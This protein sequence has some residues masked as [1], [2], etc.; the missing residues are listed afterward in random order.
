MTGFLSRG[1]GNAR[2]DKQRKNE[3]VYRDVIKESDFVI[4]STDNKDNLKEDREYWLSVDKEFVRPLLQSSDAHN[5]ESVGE[6]FTWIKSDLTFEG[7]RQIKFEPESRVSVELD[8]PD[9]KES[10]LILDKIEIEGNSIELNKNLN[11]IIGGRSTG[12][13][14]LLNTIAKKVGYDTTVNEEEVNTFFDLKDFKDEDFKVVWADDKTSDNRKVTF[15][16]QEYMIEVA[17]NKGKFD[18]LIKTIVNSKGYNKY[19]DKYHQ[20]V[21][22]IQ[23]KI[24]NSILNIE[25]A[26]KK[27]TE[28][29]VKP[30]GDEVGIKYAIEA[31]E[32]KIKLFQ[33]NNPYFKKKIKEFR[34]QKAKLDDLKSKIENLEKMISVLNELWSQDP[35]NTDDLEK[36]LSSEALHYEVDFGETKGINVVNSLAETLEKIRA[37]AKIVWANK[38]EEL[39]SAASSRMCQLNNE[40]AAIKES[41][42]YCEGVQLNNKN[43]E[44]E[45]LMDK[46]QELK[47]QLKLVK[48][49]IIDKENQKKAIREE[50]QNIIALYD[51]YKTIRQKL[52]SDVKIETNINEYGDSS[53]GVAV[54]LRFKQ[55]PLRE[56]IDYLDKRNT[57]NNE[58]EGRFNQDS[59]QIIKDGI[60][61]KANSMIFNQGKTKYDFLKDIFM[62]SWKDITFSVNYNGDDFETMSQGKKAF[63][64]LSLILSYSDDRKPVL[65]DQP[66]DNLDNRGIYSELTKYILEQKVKRQ[67]IL[68]THNPNIVVGADAENI[69][70]ANQHSEHTPNPDNTKFY[71]KNGAL[72]EKSYVKNSSNFLDK[73]S[74]RE[75]VFEILEGGEEAFK[76]RENKYS[77]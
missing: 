37:N 69:I 4:H 28:T 51:E 17:K 20:Q 7:L 44:L 25:N 58:F 29:M 5:L 55:I 3:S 1:H 48:T 60:F 74:I 65:I 26:Y 76:K 18:D 11:T 42:S 36:Q 10:Y 9:Q 49:Y 19:I 40:I 77:I 63:V 68:V 6:K 54:E 31:N 16:P 8:E 53:H 39:E 38:I 15:L 50:R 41:D 61:D 46:S 59:D 12:K 45:N 72:E 35:V 66:E 27:I 33:K 21:N 14:L 43:K 62:N 2:P 64:I 24:S 70:V 71:Y 23:K 47:G 75:H 34:S 52:M 57:I 67:M 73:C 30:E 56:R 13:S 32:E 22:G